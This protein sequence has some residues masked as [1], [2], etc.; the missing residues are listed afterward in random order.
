MNPPSS[1]PPIPNFFLLY[2]TFSS[3][4]SPTSL[5]QP[6][7]SHPYSPE[8][9]YYP[10]LRHLQ[11]FLLLINSTYFPYFP[12]SPFISLLLR[13][14][15][16]FPFIFL[17]PIT[18]FFFFFL[19][20]S[21]TYFSII[22]T[23]LPYFSFHYLLTTTPTSSPLISTLSPSFLCPYFFHSAHFPNSSSHLPLL[24][25]LLVHKLHIPL[26]IPLHLTLPFPS[27]DFTSE[28]STSSANLISLHF[29]TSPSSV[30]PHFPYVTSSHFFSL[31]TLRFPTSPPLLLPHL[32]Y[33]FAHNFLSLPLLHLK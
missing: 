27:F 15:P 33:L 30:F 18:P 19:L 3:L 4:P 32:A 2:F 17:L 25:L 31:H 22:S 13:L 16:S 8:L 28:T 20:T 29:P 14:L 9:P 26:H 24:P 10:T 5:S 12:S 23:H 7:F 1:F 11:S 21:S 6:S